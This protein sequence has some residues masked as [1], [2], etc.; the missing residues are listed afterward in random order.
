MNISLIK[1]LL[2]YS[3]L[4]L[5]GSC[6]FPQINKEAPETNEVVLNKKFRINLPEDHRT[7]FMWQLNQNFDK[8]KINNLGP[9]WHGNEKGIDFNLEATAIGQTTL[10]FVLRKHTD[11]SDVKNFI[12]KIVDN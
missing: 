1:K 9:V 2:L 7:G 12:I 11:T 6:S 8:T 5:L 4:I 10:T 3:P